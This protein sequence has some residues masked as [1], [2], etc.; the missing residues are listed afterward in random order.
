MGDHS[1]YCIAGTLFGYQNYVVEALQGTNYGKQNFKN[2]ASQIIEQKITVNYYNAFTSLFSMLDV[3]CSPPYQII[4]ESTEPNENIFFI[5]YYYCYLWL[6]LMQIVSPDSTD[7]AVSIQLRAAFTKIDQKLVWI[8]VVFFL[9][10]IWGIIRFFISAPPIALNPSNCSIL[11]SHALVILQSIG[12]PGQ[13][14]SNALLFVIFND[15]IYQRL[16]PCLYACGT[17]CQGA[18]KSAKTKLKKKR[19]KRTHFVKKSLM[20]GGVVTYNNGERQSLITDSNYSVLYQSTPEDVNIK[21]KR[22]ENPNADASSINKFT[23]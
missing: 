1:D 17:R 7:S 2:F 22:L 16:C 10:R 3:Y 6:F 11:Y 19:M 4:I 13:G 15:K 5:L 14:W 20:N 18:C 23:E 21:K 9:V 8:P 12:D